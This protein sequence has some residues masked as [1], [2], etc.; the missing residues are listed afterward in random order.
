[1]NCSEVLEQTPLSLNEDVSAEIRRHLDSCP[2]CA[3][4]VSEVRAFDERLRASILR[5]E[6][7]FNIAAFEQRVMRRIAEE[8]AVRVLPD[9]VPAPRR[10]VWPWAALAIMAAGAAAMVSFVVYQGVKPKPSSFSMAA[11]HDHRLEVK[12]KQPRRWRLDIPSAEVM[13]STR[14]IPAALV[15]A[16]EST[17]FTFREA[18]L[19]K[20]N[21]GIFLHLVYADGEGKEFSLYLRHD[22]VEQT[23][24]SRRVFTTE[25]AE[26][27]IAGFHDG[28]LEALVVTDQPGDAALHIARA[29]AR[30][31]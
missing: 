5:E 14:G 11:A 9:A 4:Q 30:V 21:G 2:S 1:M 31:I 23:G 20:L 26:G 6:H 22:E 15:S 18:K 29:A 12:D 16:V 17:G 7:E 25:S 28:S 8:S 24:V 10:L 27:H 3:R 19:C 13:A